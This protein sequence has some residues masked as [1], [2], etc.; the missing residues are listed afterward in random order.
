MILMLLI[1]Q[2]V[3]GQYSLT[4]QNRGLKQNSVHCVY[5]FRFQ[6]EGAITIQPYAD[7]V[8]N[9]EEYFLKLRPSTNTRNPWFAEYW[10][11]FFQCRLRGSLETPFNQ[12]RHDSEILHVLRRMHGVAVAIWTKGRI[13]EKIN[14]ICPGCP[15]PSTALQCRIVV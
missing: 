1:V 10:E 4:M 12:V 7:P 5:T 15:R 8:E 6:V 3:P 2:L 11:D 13:H 9:F 14:L